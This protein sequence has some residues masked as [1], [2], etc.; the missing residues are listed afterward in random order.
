[1]DRRKKEPKILPLYFI[2]AKHNRAMQREKQL[3]FY[4]T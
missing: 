3:I 4:G 1:M 2:L